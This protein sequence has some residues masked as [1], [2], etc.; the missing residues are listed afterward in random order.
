MP[1][2]GTFSFGDSGFDPALNTFP[3]AGLPRVPWIMRD[4]ASDDEYEFAVNPLDMSFPLV[5]KRL[6]TQYTTAGKPITWEGRSEV[7]VVSFSGTILYREH[8]E[9][10]LEWLEKSTQIALTDDF[11]RNFWLFLTEF[12][13]SRRYSADFPWRHEYSA[14][15]LIINWE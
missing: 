5:Q 3:I 13:P 12:S 4:V 10:M 11:G 14:S 2:F 15:G 6:T 8:Y 9:I 1:K 7:P